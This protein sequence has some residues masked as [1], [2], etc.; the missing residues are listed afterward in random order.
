MLRL[1]NQFQILQF[2]SQLIVG[3]QFEKIVLQTQDS[4]N[5]EV[6]AYRHAWVALLNVVQCSPIDARPLRYLNGCELSAA[7]GLV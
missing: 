3:S 4:Q 6:R 5:I 7:C 1:A 2:P